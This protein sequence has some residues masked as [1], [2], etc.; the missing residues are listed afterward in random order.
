MFFVYS[1]ILI[2]KKSAP[3]LYLALISILS[4][5]QMNLKLYRFTGT[6]YSLSKI[7]SLPLSLSQIHLT[8]T[9]AFNYSTT[10]FF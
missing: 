1:H 5:K 7:E 6:N 8:C 4:T 3:N 2:K 9:Y 10:L